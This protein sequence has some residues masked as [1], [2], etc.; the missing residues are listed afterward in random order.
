[1]LV[2]DDAAFCATK[3]AAKQIL[4]A[5]PKFVHFVELTRYSIEVLREGVQEQRGLVQLTGQISQSLK[6]LAYC[7][8]VDKKADAN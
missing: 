5:G 1:L 4:I 2:L 3:L 6:V 8:P 7:K